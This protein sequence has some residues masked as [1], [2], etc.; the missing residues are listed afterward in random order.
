MDVALPFVGNSTLGGGCL[1]RVIVLSMQGT[2]LTNLGVTEG[3][4]KTLTRKLVRNAA[5]YARKIMV[6]RRTL[7]Q[8]KAGMNGPQWIRPS[9]LGKRKQ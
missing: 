2:L 5:M 7:E 9:Q 3:Q 6:T 8:A 1:T 4:V